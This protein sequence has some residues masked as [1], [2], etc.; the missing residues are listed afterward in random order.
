MFKDTLNKINNTYD[1]NLSESIINDISRLMAIPVNINDDIQIFYNNLYKCI[2]QKQLYIL[3]IRPIINM[4]VY[5]FI[6][7]CNIPIVMYILDKVITDIFFPISPYQCILLSNNYTKSNLYINIDIKEI[8]KINALMFE[9]NNLLLGYKEC[10][11]NLK[12]SM[13]NNEIGQ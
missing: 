3:Q 9:K 10:L 12:E 4:N 2:S 7:G 5:S 11:E 1:M 13:D 8:N 6:L